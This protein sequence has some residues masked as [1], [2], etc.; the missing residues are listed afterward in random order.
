HRGFSIKITLAD[1]FKLPSV[2]QIAIHIGRA[3]KDKYNPLEA[4]E[5]KEYYPLSFAQ[6]RMYILQR[7]HPRGLGYNLFLTW[8]LEGGVDIDRFSQTFK[9]LIMRHEVLRTSIKMVGEEPVQTVHRCD[10]TDFEIKYDDLT[11]TRGEVPVDSGSLESTP[12]EDLMRSFVR[13]FDLSRAPL[14]R[15]GL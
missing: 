15:V 12:R 5:K 14:L 9:Q 6:Q 3:A 10:E 13:P 4:A 8:I 2:R 11:G 7:V 1:I